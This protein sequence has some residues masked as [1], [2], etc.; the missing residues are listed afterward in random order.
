MA[1][2]PDVPVEV[3]GCDSSR[4]SSY[5]SSSGTE[6]ELTSPCV[7]LLQRLRSHM[8]SELARKRKIDRNPRPKGKIKARGQGANGPKSVSPSQHVSE[9][10]GEC[11]TVSSKRLFCTA[12]REE[13]SLVSCVVRNDVKSVK[14]QAGKKRLDAKEKPSMTSLM[15]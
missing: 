3:D 13:L 11:L 5:P 6:T 10:P 1:E 8:T 15:L 4:S 12:C 9:N 7:S 14:H 2:A